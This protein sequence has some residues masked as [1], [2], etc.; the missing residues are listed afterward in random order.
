MLDVRLLAIHQAV[1]CGR[2]VL[3]RRSSGENDGGQVEETQ[4]GSPLRRAS[5]LSKV[6]LERQFHVQRLRHVRAMLGDGANVGSSCEIH[7]ITP[8][9]S[10]ISRWP[11]YIGVQ[12]YTLYERRGPSR[13][14]VREAWNSS[15]LLVLRAINFMVA[16]RAFLGIEDHEGQL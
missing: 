13:T 14:T 2:G 12:G 4:S 15:S 11:T 8:F 1:A 9:G 16:P 7:P 5:R 10:Y 6:D 3:Y